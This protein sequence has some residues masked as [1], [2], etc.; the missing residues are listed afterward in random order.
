MQFNVHEEYWD[1]PFYGNDQTNHTPHVFINIVTALVNAVL[2]LVFRMRVEH[3]EIIDEFKGKKNGAVLVAPHH[4][5][6]D[7][8]ILYICMRPRG[9]VRLMARE[10]LFYAGNGLLGEIIS[11][12]GAF[13]IKRGKAD[14]IALK[15]AA[16]MLKNGEWVG[17][18]PEGTRRGKGSGK[19]RLHAGAAVVARMGKAPIIPVGLENL[20]EIKRKGERVR[21]KKITVRFGNPISLDSFSFLPKDERMDACAWYTMRQA[22]ALTNNCA[23]EDVDMVA[24][25][26]DAKDYTALFAEHPIEPIDPATLPDFRKES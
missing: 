10:S 12:A 18:F 9:W 8:V 24:L 2:R 19:P 5:Y 26:P 20:S 21:F 23:D 17:I 3:Q 16:R 14:R 6:L 13:P 22:Y 7:V 25:F 15:R 4:S 1:R 11:R